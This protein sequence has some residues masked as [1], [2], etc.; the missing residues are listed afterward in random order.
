MQ[1]TLRIKDDVYRRAKAKAGELGLSLTRFLEEAVEDRLTRLEER[2]AGRIV[3]PVSSVSGPVMSE[4]EF[5][6][7][8]E[9]ADLE[10]DRSKLS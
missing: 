1:T 5:R 6:K 9:A 2:P 8:V 7:R 10:Y 3:L 4:E